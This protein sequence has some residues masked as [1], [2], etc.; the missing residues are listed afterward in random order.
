MHGAL[1]VWLTNTEA[2]KGP[3]CDSRKHPWG[4]SPGEILM[5]ISKLSDSF[6]RGPPPP[7]VLQAMQRVHAPLNTRVYLEVHP[8]SLVP[9]CK[10]PP[11]CDN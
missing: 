10:L 5:T 6:S 3:S 8:L 7:G 2:P 11:A 1:Q 9:R 4:D